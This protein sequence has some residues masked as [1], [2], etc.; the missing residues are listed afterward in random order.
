VFDC[1]KWGVESYLTLEDAERLQAELVK[2]IAKMKE[3]MFRLPTLDDRDDAADGGEL[4]LHQM[5]GSA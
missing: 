3:R 2:A 1:R 4:H 5:G